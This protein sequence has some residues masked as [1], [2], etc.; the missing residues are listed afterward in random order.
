MALNIF[1]GLCVLGEGF[2]AYV[3][4]NLI[5]DGRRRGSDSR[6]APL[7]YRIPAGDA[8]ARPMR[9]KVIQINVPKASVKSTEL[10]RPTFRLKERN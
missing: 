1:M 10:D 5:R 2:L 7:Y 3:L 4:V 6:P 8:R 9:R